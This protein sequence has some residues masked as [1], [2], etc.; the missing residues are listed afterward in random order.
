M[1]INLCMTCGA[2]C[3]YYRASFYWGEG[4]DAAPGGVPV[5][6]TEKLNDFYRVMRGTNQS[7]PRCTALMG[8]IGA[9]VSCS[10]YARRASV[11][12]SFEPAW[13]EGVPNERCDQA[14][15]SFGLPPL[16]PEL[17]HGP[18]DLPQAA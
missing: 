16:R 10:I 7:R 13:A 2:C 9:R 5:E 15:A 3:A 18:G 14:R 12:R 6:L 4:D 11:C 1:A 8:I 17:W